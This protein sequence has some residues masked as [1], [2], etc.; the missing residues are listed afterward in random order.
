[1]AKMDG[2]GILKGIGLAAVGAGVGVVG[3]GLLWRAS[4][5]TPMWREVI[6]AGV[7]VVAIAAASYWGK[8][9]V[10]VAIA[11]GTFYFVIA[12]VAMRT[13]A[14]AQ[15]GSALNSALAAAG[16]S[17]GTAPAAPALPAATPA[18]SGTAP[19]RYPAYSVMAY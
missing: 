14:S 19:A 9:V 18:A 2:M 8:P 5:L 12:S 4:S 3:A 11:T 13:G 10:G 1:M 7:G 16:L 15:A 17:S 6:M